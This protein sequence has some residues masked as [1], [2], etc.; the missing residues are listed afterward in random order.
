MSE[1]NEMRPETIAVLGSRRYCQDSRAEAIMSVIGATNWYTESNSASR[2]HSSTSMVL[3]TY[4]FLFV[5]EVFRKLGASFF[6]ATLIRS[7]SSNEL[8][9]RPSI[10]GSLLPFCSVESSGVEEKT[11]QKW[12]F[13][14]SD[15]PS[16]RTW[17]IQT[18]GSVYIPHAGMLVSS[19]ETEP[20]LP[21]RR[22]QI[23]LAYPL[24]DD[25]KRYDDIPNDDPFQMVD[26]K[27]WAKNWMPS[28][29]NYAVALTK[30][31][32]PG[33]QGLVIRGILLKQVDIQPTTLVKVGVFTTS[34]F[35]W[36]EPF[37]NTEP[38]RQVL[39]WVVL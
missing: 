16:V 2:R 17:R 30:S 24:E 20:S 25:L 22:C 6:N 23:I 10:Q 18:D 35:M 36:R 26:L 11:V 14:E 21:L 13:P 9:R 39:N 38:A 4:S 31:I 32:V 1:L 33:Y 19:D 27:D 8:L 12:S 34:S 7:L 29:P 3:G 28:S 37:L 15:H 5:E